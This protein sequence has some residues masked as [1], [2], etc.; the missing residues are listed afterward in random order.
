ME[1]QTTSKPWGAF[2]QF[3]HNES[4]T[5]KVL[6]V[7]AGEAFSLQTHA[8]REEFWKV[9]S[10][11]PRITIGDVTTRA[12]AGDEFSI[13]AGTAHRIEAEG[14]DAEILEIARGAFDEDD[15]IRLQDKYGRV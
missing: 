3:T 13:A 11:T 7:R 8:H 6:F 10:G 15:I 4:T 1:P 5:V 9:L 2:R 12:K 14:A